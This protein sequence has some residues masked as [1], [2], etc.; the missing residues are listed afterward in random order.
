MHMNF[1]DIR[2]AVDSHV[3]TITFCRPERN[4]ALRPETLRELCE[5]LDQVVPDDSVKAIVLKADGRHF[6]AGA[7]FAF[8]EQLT[9]MEAPAIRKQ[10]Y[11]HFQGAAKRLY[12]CPKPTLALVQ[13]A[14][15]T[16]GCELALACDFRVMSKKAFLQESWVRLGIMPPLGGLF[17]LPRYVGLGRAMNMALRGEQL[18]ADEALTSGLALEIVAAD[19]L[20]RRGMELAQELASIAPLA[21]A[22]IKEAIQRG[23][24]TGMDAEWSANVS[25]Q[26][27]LL[28]SEDFA[29]GLKAAKERRP[30]RFCGR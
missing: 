21:Y 30:A 24:E 29:E 8:L 7:D 5:A 27:T 26:A 25:T 15:V 12:R 23:L 1:D 20:E 3:A 16:V 19:D 13:G 17:L 22:A 4:N 28:T 11:A 2:V 6:S 14:A 18:A 10:V 9:E